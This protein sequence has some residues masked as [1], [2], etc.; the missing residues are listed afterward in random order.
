MESTKAKQG[1]FAL[2]IRHS[3]SVDLF[4]DGNCVATQL[5]QSVR[6]KPPTAAADTLYVRPSNV[7]SS[8]A[9]LIVRPTTNAK[10]VRT[11]WPPVR[12][13]PFDRECS[14]TTTTTTRG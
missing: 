10:Y 13:Y 14:V 11:L 6:E 7:F 9:T 1:A 8:S 4:L 2:L 5:S 12:F 3:Y